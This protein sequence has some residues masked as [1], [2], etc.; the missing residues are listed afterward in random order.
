MNDKK[1]TIHE[2]T[3]S[4]YKTLLVKMITNKY[5]IKCFK[6]NIDRERSFFFLKKKI[7]HYL[8]KTK[9]TTKFIDSKNFLTSV[10]F[11]LNETATYI[12]P[13]FYF[14]HYNLLINLN[15]VYTYLYEYFLIKNLIYPRSAKNWRNLQSNFNEEIFDKRLGITN[16]T[17]FSGVNC[18]P[19]IFFNFD[20][21]GYLKKG[22]YILKNSGLF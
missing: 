17:L 22:Y 20:K 6:I 19:F 10:N 14:G 8:R 15:Y 7:R 2:S 4:V 21:K 12:P 11:S 16:Y 9:F 5:L 18:I 3:N 1:I 13:T